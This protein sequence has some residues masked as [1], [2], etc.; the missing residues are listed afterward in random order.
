LTRVAVSVVVLAA[1]AAL[2]P[3]AYAVRDFS[4]TARNII[5]SGQWG[6]IPSADQPPTPDQAAQQARL[7]DGLTPLFDNVSNGD[8]HRYFKSE[9][10]TPKGEGPLEREPVPRKGVR[11]IRDRF[12]V[13]HIS[14]AR[15]MTTSPGAPAGRWPT[16]ASCCS[17]RLATTPAW[18]WWT[19]PASL[20]ST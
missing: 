5:P 1:L 10:L 6:A 9:R 18:R 15:R 12:N 3:S 4:S 14:T 20:P 2:A 8:L 17:S 16:I 19:H 11:L 13:P 7:Y